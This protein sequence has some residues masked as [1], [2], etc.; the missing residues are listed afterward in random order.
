M[1]IDDVK[2]NLSFHNSFAIP[3]MGR[4]DSLAMLWKSNME[5]DLVTYSNHHIHVQISLHG[6]TVK[7]WLLGFYGYSEIHC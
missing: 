6:S 1:Y 5:V 4:S 3:S 7:W 2:R